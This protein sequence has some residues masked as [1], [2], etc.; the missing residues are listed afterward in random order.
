MTEARRL[1][2]LLALGGFLL[3]VAWA[4]R[5]SVALEGPARDH[6]SVLRTLVVDRGPVGEPPA[7]PWL[8]GAL[9]WLPA[10]SVAHLA[11]YAS[12]R[13]APEGVNPLYGTLIALS[14]L[15]LVALGVGRLA[16][17]AVAR[18]VAP[19]TA[20]ACAALVVAATPL[21]PLALTAPGHAELAVFALAALLLDAEDRAARAVLA[22]AIAAVEPRAAG[23]L[24]LGLGRPGV[25]IVAAG[26]TWAAQLPYEGARVA[27][28]AAHPLPLVALVGLAL[29]RRPAEWLVVVATLALIPPARALV[30]LAPLVFAGLVELAAAAHRA[31][32]PRTAAA[33][34]LLLAALGPAAPLL[35]L[36]PQLVM[37]EAAFSPVWL[38]GLGAAH[39]GLA[40]ALSSREPR[41]GVVGLLA[42]GL[43]LGG[44]TLAATA[45]EGGTPLRGV[46]RA[47]PGFVDAGHPS[48][49]WFPP[50]GT[51][52]RSL[53]LVTAMD[54]TAALAPGE[55][56][57][58][59]T[60]RDTQGREL[61]YPLAWGMD[62][63]SHVDRDAGPAPG[64]ALLKMRAAHFAL[65]GLA[66]P[67][68]SLGQ[69]YRTRCALPF[70][71]EVAEVRVAA[72]HKACRLEITSVWLGD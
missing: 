52:A 27:T 12:D 26:L 45:R 21:G 51:R 55:V 18:G 33:L 56:V 11:S 62:T 30:V 57:A 17:A 44:L 36:P 46:W 68:L 20:A 39:V 59:V 38:L 14:G 67:K 4:V 9:P 65:T 43:A 3:V 53:E 54:P 19:G 2:A 49:T 72:H 61:D 69:S 24:V 23:W 47:G 10:F 5:G 70:P 40:L 34:A 25:P 6:A 37:T 31:G 58:L 71:L 8:P 41:A 50:A 16:R 60:I 15:A 7:R 42:C 13:F 28:L 32:V 35:R 22:A 63:F 48:E 29:R 1:T 66:L 64:L